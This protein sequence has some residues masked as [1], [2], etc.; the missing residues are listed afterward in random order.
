MFSQ[1]DIAA[2]WDSFDELLQSLNNEIEILSSKIIATETLLTVSQ[3]Q[4]AALK[5]QLTAREIAYK[6]SVSLY[7]ALKQS[8]TNS[9]N[10]LHKAQR[11]NWI[12][13]GVALIAGGAA[14]YFATH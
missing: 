5:A 2:T 6:E 3:E 8:L 10:S 14:V 4:L 9:E 7:E 1:S 12:L 13:G 11:L